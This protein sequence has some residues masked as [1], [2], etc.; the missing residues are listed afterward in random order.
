MS[1]GDREHW[2]FE[3]QS[4]DRIEAMQRGDENKIKIVVKVDENYPY[5]LL[6]GEGHY[7]DYSTC[8]WDLGYRFKRPRD[9]AQNENDCNVISLPPTNDIAKIE[10]HIKTVLAR[11]SREYKFDLQDPVARRVLKELEDLIKF[12]KELK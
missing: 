6:E 8:N 4:G 11:I 5:I 9:E 1:L 12:V 7:R 3:P 10:E 2:P